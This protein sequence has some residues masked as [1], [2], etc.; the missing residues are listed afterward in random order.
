L[1]RPQLLYPDAD[2]DG[3]GDITATAVIA[4]VQPS[5]HVQNNTDCN[6]TDASLEI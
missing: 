2:G 6:D 1:R 4:A 5:G 3:F